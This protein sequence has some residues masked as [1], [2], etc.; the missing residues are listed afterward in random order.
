MSQ[1]DLLHGKAFGLAPDTALCDVEL[2]GDYTVTLAGVNARCSKK[3][4]G[5]WYAV[6]ARILSSG[7]ITKKNGGRLPKQTPLF[8]STEE[9][10]YFFFVSAL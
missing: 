8:E 2:N 9:S 10:G 3:R 5:N 7:P 1:S 6:R 4:M